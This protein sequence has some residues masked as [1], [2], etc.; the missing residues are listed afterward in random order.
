VKSAKE[1]GL[2]AAAELV[3]PSDVLGIPLGPGQPA[4]FLHALS[5]RDDW[6]DLRVFG[7]LLLDLYPLFAKKGVQLLSGFFGPA[8]RA[9]LAA[10]HDVRFVPGDFRRFATVAEQ[11]APRVMATAVAP[12]GPDGR[13]SLSLHAGATVEALRRCGRDPDRLL[14][15]EVNPALPRTGGIPPDHT[16]DLGPDEIDVLVEADRPPATLDGPGPTAIERAIAEH[17]ARLV[18]EGATL[19]TGIGGVPD[20]IASLLAE[21]PGGDYGVHSEMFTTGL[22]HLHQAGKVSNARKGIFEGVSV[23]TFALGSK[24]LH[25]WLHEN[26]EVRFLPVDI[27]NDPTIIAANRNMIA[28]NG[29]LSVDLAGQVVADNIGGRQHSGIGGHEDFVA[30]ASLESDDRSLVCL[31]S[32]AQ[33]GG[34]RVSRIVARLPRGSIVTTP[35]HAVD[36]VVTE[37]G[38]AELRGRTVAERAEALVEIAHP[39]IRDALRAG[40][41]DPEIS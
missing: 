11:L 9:L 12:P 32:T 18:P 25:D 2:E 14:V 39:S 10:G 20:A 8:E 17:V 4:S 15:A 34:R 37:Y 3:R 31:P 38:A 21:G 30:G 27:V 1:L 35:R 28:I 16:H 36:L 7:A 6:H 40:E 26:D 41:D 24:E 29:G 5:R 13:F 33:V 22:M 19:Q 23:C